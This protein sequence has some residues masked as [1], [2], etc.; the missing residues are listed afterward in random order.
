M[1]IYLRVFALALLIGQNQPADSKNGESDAEKEQVERWMQRYADEATGYQFEVAGDP[2]VE[3][4]FR[5]Q[6][7]L[8]WMNPVV[9]GVT[10]A[11][12]RLYVWTAD[13]CPEVIGSIFSFIDAR[14]PDRSKRLLVDEF[15]SLSER[16][17]AGSRK[18][19]EAKF[20]KTEKP[21]VQ[22]KAIDDAPA[23]SD[24][25]VTRLSQMREL[26]RQFS[27]K[28]EEHDAWSELRLLAQP[29]YRF[30]SRREDILDGGLF[31]FV[32]GTDPEIILVLEARRAG[33]AFAWHYGLA[34]FT[35]LPLRVSHGETEVWQAGRYR[36][37]TV[38]DPKDC[39]Q[40]THVLAVL[41][42]TLP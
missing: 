4:E 31:A 40:G 19:A 34:R 11:H 38:N 21:G 12:G 3:L 17:L 28:F 14:R 2:P 15:H 42:K 27:A 6:S 33:T 13:G 41:D 8:R 16:A 37:S 29:I 18:S 36:N 1:A 39:Y 26:S 32:T 23:P 25:A 7:T 5:S 35:H 10:T 20:W 22:F 30:E 9:A 24:S